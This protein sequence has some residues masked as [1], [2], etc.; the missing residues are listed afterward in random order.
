[1]CAYARVR[2]RVCACAHIHVCACECV[3][4]NIFIYIDLRREGLQV[5]CHEICK[6]AFLIKMEKI[7]GK[8]MSTL[9]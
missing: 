4:V 2:L 3:Q 7:R 5:S 9:Y 6:E 8:Q 1:V